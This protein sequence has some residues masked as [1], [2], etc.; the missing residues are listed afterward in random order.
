VP[1]HLLDEHS[2]ASLE[3]MI[4]TQTERSKNSCRRSRKDRSHVGG[5]GER[6]AVTPHLIYNGKEDIKEF[7]FSP[8]VR[9]M[10]GTDVLSLE[11]NIKGMTEPNKYIEFQEESGDDLTDAGSAPTQ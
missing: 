11:L 7:G 10:P 8:N 2:F 5:Y 3:N 1:E 4:E 6:N 9:R